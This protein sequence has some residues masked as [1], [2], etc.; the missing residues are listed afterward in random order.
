[1]IS[2]PPTIW[3]P[4]YKL[5]FEFHEYLTIVARIMVAMVAMVIIGH[6]NVT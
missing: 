4:N 6:Y 5:V 1:M 3:A 2:I